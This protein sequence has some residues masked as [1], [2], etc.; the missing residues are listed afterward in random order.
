MEAD[1][2]ACPTSVLLESSLVEIFAL[3]ILVG[4]LAE[5]R[6][7]LYLAHQPQPYPDCPPSARAHDQL[8]S[9]LHLLSAS[10]SPPGPHPRR[11]LT[12]RPPY[13]APRPRGPTYQQFPY[14]TSPGGTGSPCPSSL[15]I[16]SAQC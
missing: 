2:L 9:L 15:P 7:G 16:C 4:V 10:V 13:L 5:P 8:L 11:P 14:K 12:D 1:H 3:T 6:S